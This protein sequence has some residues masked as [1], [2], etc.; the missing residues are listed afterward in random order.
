MSTVNNIE[1]QYN[2]QGNDYNIS[3]I[4]NNSTDYTELVRDI[5]D[6]QEDIQNA[7]PDEI[8]SK[9]TEKLSE[10][11]QQLESFKESIYRLHETFNKI[12]LNTERLQQTKAYFEAGKFREADALLNPKEIALELEQLSAIQ[13]QKKQE[14]DKTDSDLIEI[15]NEY[16]IKAQIWTT[17]Y[18]EPDWYKEAKKYFEEALKVART[19]Q[20]LFEYAMF[21][22][23][24]KQFSEAMPLYEEALKIHRKLAEENP[25]AYL[26]DVAMTLNNLAA[27]YSDINEYPKAVE[28]YEEVLKIHRKLAEENPNV[29][30]PDVAKTLNNL[31]NLYWSINEY[32][33]A[34][35]KYEEALKIR[36]KL[37]EDESPKVFISYS[38][39]SESH[40][41][42]VLK[43]AYLLIK[44]GVDAILDTWELKAGKDKDFFMENSLRI[45]DKVLLIMTPN[46][47]IKAENR[48]G[49]VG[50]EISMIRAEKFTNQETEKFIPIVRFGK[51]EDCTP[52]FAKSL[53]DIDM[54]N[55]DDFEKSFEDL[56]RTIFEVPQFEKPTIGNRPQ[57]NK[58]NYSNF[59][60]ERL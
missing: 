35:E 26:P 47:K 46:Y 22:Q 55:D 28:E 50:S 8:K 45:S 38:W 34:L 9:K 27:L 10:K 25:N 18:S 14:L 3:H 7:F 37:A 42:W 16:L 31:A 20:V 48:K 6:L 40:K 4:V 30:L 36:K 29:Y 60:K 39:D 56:L 54:S 17:L 49:G 1:K 15:S 58:E 2:V 24:H 52:L 23:E 51:R 13:R 11:Q 32:P 43:L 57:F 12:P 33:K 5:Q 53:I 41:E 44:N 19:V 59:F 21:L